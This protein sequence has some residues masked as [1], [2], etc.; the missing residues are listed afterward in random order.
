M[1]PHL[2]HDAG[3]VTSSGTTFSISAENPTW[4]RRC[5]SEVQ[6][7]GDDQLRDAVARLVRQ[8]E[9]GDWV[10]KDGMKIVNNIAFLD[11]KTLLGRP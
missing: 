1:P 5:T 3:T 4:A 6:M 11:V 10:N 2:G 9:M 7:A 8:L